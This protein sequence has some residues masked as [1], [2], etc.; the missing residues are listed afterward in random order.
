MFYMLSCGI[1]VPR[2]TLHDERY[3]QLFADS[4]RAE[5]FRFH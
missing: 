2:E 3:S 5:R 4:E 1:V